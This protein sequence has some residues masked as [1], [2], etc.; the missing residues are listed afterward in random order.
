MTAKCPRDLAK[1]SERQ[2]SFASFDTANVRPINVSF[3]GQFLL[4]PLQGFPF[5]ADSIA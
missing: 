3:G 4:S 1:H 2:V 5:F